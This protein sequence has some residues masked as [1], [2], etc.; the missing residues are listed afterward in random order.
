MKNVDPHESQ[1]RSRQVIY[2]CGAVVAILMLGFVIVGVVME[3]PQLWSKGPG[4]FFADAGPRSAFSAI[5]AVL[6]AA[7]YSLLV[8]A[9][10]R[11]GPPQFFAVVSVLALAAQLWL[12]I[13]ALFLGGS[14]TA[15][16]AALFIP[17]YIGAGVAAVWVAALIAQR[18]RAA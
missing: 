8:R 10:R 15:S 11:P 17:F 18:I 4:A 6:S 13:S 5:I 16:I 9:A 14:S 3:A 12:T 2:A 7:P 1:K